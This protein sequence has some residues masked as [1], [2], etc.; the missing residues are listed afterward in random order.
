MPLNLIHLGADSVKCSR[1]A[2]IKYIQTQVLVHKR[3]NICVMA[4]TILKH[5]I[6]FEHLR[7]CSSKNSFSPGVLKLLKTN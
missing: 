2:F 1:K 6:Q 4:L 3:G 5:L 7:N